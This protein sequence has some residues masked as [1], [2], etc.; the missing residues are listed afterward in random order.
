M[1]WEILIN[2][3]LRL[4]TRSCRF[5]IIWYVENGSEKFN[6]KESRCINVYYKI[7]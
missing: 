3:F 2:P 4:M 6:D 1:A 5:T 7:P